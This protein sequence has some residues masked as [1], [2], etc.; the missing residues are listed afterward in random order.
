MGVFIPSVHFPVIN[1]GFIQLSSTQQLFG[2]GGVALAIITY[3]GRVMETVGNTLMPLTSE[4]AIVVVLSQ[5]LVLFLFS[6]QSLS[7]GLHSIGLPAIP[8]VL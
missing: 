4:A 5:A 1:L 3:S 6:S 2:I 8:L 7:D